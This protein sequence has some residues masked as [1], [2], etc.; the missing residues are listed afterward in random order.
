M[1]PGDYLQWILNN[2]KTSAANVLGRDE[3][4]RVASCVWK[5]YYALEKTAPPFEQRGNKGLFIAAVPMVA[6]YQ[7]LRHDFALEEQPALEL[8]EKMLR[9]AYATRIGP[10]TTIAFNALY[11]LRPIRRLMLARMAETDEPEGFRFE[12]H[13]DPSTVMSFDVRACPI[14]N[15]AKKHGVSE[16]VP[17]ICRLDDLFAEQLIGMELRREGTI[18]MGA[19][20][21][22]FRYVRT[23]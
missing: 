12:H 11:Q 2:G 20:H 17:I 8:A 4:E 5:R 13:N 23:R 3:A 1:G 10:V 9:D 19:D 16:I 22:D 14:V 18:G 6:L 15:F 21:C 7:S